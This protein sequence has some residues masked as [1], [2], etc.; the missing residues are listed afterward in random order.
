MLALGSDD[1]CLGMTS[2]SPDSRIVHRETHNYHHLERSGLGDEQY[3]S[4][5]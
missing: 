5:A 1:A 4:D 3:S 2:V